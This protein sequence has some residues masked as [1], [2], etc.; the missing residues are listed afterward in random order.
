MSIGER[1]RV[2]GTVTVQSG[3]FASS[4]SSG[5]ALQDES[6]GI[7]VVDADHAFRPG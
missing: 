2:F 1:V 3:A 4:I 7:Y 6:A 5:F